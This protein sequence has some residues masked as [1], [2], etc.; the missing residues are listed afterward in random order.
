MSIR[1][2]A[3]TL[4][5]ALVRAAGQLGVTQDRMA[6][7]IEE[8]S[9]GFLGMFGK[10]VVIKAWTKND[11]SNTRPDRPQRSDRRDEPRRDGRGPRPDHRQNTRSQEDLVAGAKSAES[12]DNGTATERRSRSERGGESSARNDD[13]RPHGRSRRPDRHQN[14]FQNEDRAAAYAQSEGEDD[15]Y[16]R[17]PAPPITE[18]QTQQVKAELSTFAAELGRYMLG[19]TVAVETEQVGERMIFDLKSE[20]L[21]AQ[22]TKNLKIA[23]AF[24][25]LIRKKTRELK[26]DLPFRVFVDAMKTRLLREAELAEMAKDFSN[27]VHESKQPMVLN[28]RRS[29]DRKIIHM[30]LDQDDRVVTKSIGK[31][32][33]RKLMILPANHTGEVEA[34]H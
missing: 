30:A 14:R 32:P 10:K 7:A 23:E 5:L 26:Q 3:K 18:E 16:E 15:D 28:Y 9:V 29:Y 33:N 6:Y 21:A 12:R 17:A 20:H 24:E 31:G 1:V 34:S 13:R 8:K 19:E 25:H 27:K 2:E 11:R 22:I 4:D